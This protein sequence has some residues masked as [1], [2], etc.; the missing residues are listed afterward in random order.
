MKSIDEGGSTLLDNSMIMFCS[1][2]F[3]GDRHQA[4]HMPILL[5]GRGGGSLTPGQVIDFHDRGDENRR[6]CSLYL[7]LMDRMG[8][9]LPSFGDTSRRLAEI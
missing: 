1:N 2:L 9:K 5:A 7:S 8:V 6:A 4:D 3:D